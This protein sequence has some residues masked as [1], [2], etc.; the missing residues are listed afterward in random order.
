M[1]TASAKRLAEVLIAR[2]P[3]LNGWTVEISE[4][5]RRT[6]GRCLYARRIIRLSRSFVELNTLPLVVEV[7]QHEIAHALTPYHGHDAVWKR[8]AIKLGAKPRRCCH[9]A[10]M[11][12]GWSAVCPGCGR[13][14]RKYRRPRRGSVYW[15]RGCGPDA[16]RLQF[17]KELDHPEVE[18][19][20]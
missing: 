19:P 8:L 5:S 15:C 10:I 13:T 9:E 20:T 2:H 6:L 17:E 18:T 16:G 1:Q 12:R 4:R 14:C 3:A 11:P 7:I